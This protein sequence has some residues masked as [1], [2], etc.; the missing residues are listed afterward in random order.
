MIIKPT[1]V[2]YENTTKKAEIV[3][4]RSLNGRALDHWGIVLNPGGV[5][6]GDFISKYPIE[7]DSIVIESEEFHPPL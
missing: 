3:R 1:D 5:I 7:I 6:T 2:I 4:V